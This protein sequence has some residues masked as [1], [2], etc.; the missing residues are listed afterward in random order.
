MMKAFSIGRDDACALL[1]PVLKGEECEE[2]EAGDVALGR[3][4][5]ED[6]ALLARRLQILA[7]ALAP[8]VPAR[9][10]R[11]TAIAGV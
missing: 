6:S 9:A 7:Q 2:G 3:E 10:W 1:T 8:W 11:G 5:G 4:D